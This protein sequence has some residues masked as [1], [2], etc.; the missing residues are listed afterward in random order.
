MALGFGLLALVAASMD[1][2]NADFHPRYVCNPAD[3]GCRQPFWMPPPFWDG[4][5]PGEPADA[6]RD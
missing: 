6:G 3:F 1:C 4:S 5:Y 2:G